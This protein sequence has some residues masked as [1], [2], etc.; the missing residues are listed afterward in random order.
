MSKVI[1]L[2][3]EATAVQTALSANRFSTVEDAVADLAAG[4]MVIVIDSPDRENE[5]DLV[6]AAEYVTPQAMHFMAVHARGLICMPMLRETLD[7]LDIPPMVARNT[8]RRRT[9]FHVS[10]DQVSTS[11]GISA[12]ER[13]KTVR[14]LADPLSIADDFV[15]PGHMF[16]LAY[17]PEGVLARAGHTEASIDLMR[18]AGL[19]PAAVICEIADDD[20]EMARVPRL[21]KF[22]REHGMRILTIESLVRYISERVENKN[23]AQELPHVSNLPN[24][25]CRMGGAVIT[26]V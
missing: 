23:A 26:G 24:P 25:P 6:I 8:D 17:H 11:T 2:V 14:A 10:V 7:R 15:Q 4:K 5:G 12:S 19:A 22:A 3:K 20:G 13:A 21:M 16:P 1:E 18:L 9:A